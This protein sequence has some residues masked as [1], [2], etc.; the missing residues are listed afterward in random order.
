MRIFKYPLELVD[1]QLIK[2]PANSRI[3]TVQVQYGKP[4]IWALVESDKP[5][6]QDYKIS[7]YGTGH[8]VPTVPGA[9]IGTFQ[10]N[11]GGLVLH[12]F[13]NYF[14]WTPNGN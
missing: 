8:D 3:L 10:M 9:Y 7:M 1:T 4:V 5:A 13:R 11:N 2:M 12:V 6:N 14:T